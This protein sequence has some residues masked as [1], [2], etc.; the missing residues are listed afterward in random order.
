MKTTREQIHKAKAA[1][2]KALAALPYEEKVR[3]MEQLQQAGKALIAARS[4]LP[5]AKR[6]Q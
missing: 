3:I 1:R 2:R 4:H 6:K 5:A